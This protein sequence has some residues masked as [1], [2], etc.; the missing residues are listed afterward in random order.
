M[1]LNK[2]FYDQK[3]I[4]RGHNLLRDRVRLVMII[5]VQQLNVKVQDLQRELDFFC[6]LM[7]RRKILQSD[8]RR[9]NIL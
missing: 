9:R 6:G 7:L 8:R 3:R 1:R 5:M 4:F 2:L